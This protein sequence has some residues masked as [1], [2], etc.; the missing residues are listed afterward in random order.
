MSQPPHDHES[1]VNT[2]SPRAED[3]SNVPEPDDGVSTASDSQD[4]P[5]TESER[6]D[7][8]D[9]VEPVEARPAD[10]TSQADEPT[11]E[12]TEGDAEVAT[13]ATDPVSDAVESGADEAGDSAAEVID[14]ETADDIDIADTAEAEATSEDGSDADTEQ[15]VAPARR[16]R[17]RTSQRRRVRTGTADLKPRPRGDEEPS[18]RQVTVRRPVTP[19]P[20]TAEDDDH[21]ALLPWLTWHFSALFGL[22]VLALLGTMMYVAMRDTSDVLT[23][24]VLDADENPV[25][26]AIVQYGADRYRTD[27]NGEVRVEVLDDD[28]VL[29]IAH[30]GYVTRRATFTDEHARDQEVTLT[31]VEDAEAPES[32]NGSTPESGIAD[33]GEIAWADVA[34]DPEIAQ[35]GV[36]SGGVDSLSTDAASQGSNSGQTAASATPNEASG[37]EIA[38]KITNIDHEPV[39]SAWITDGTNFV[40]ADDDGNFVFPPGAIAP[41]TELTVSAPGYHRSKITAPEDGESIAFQME[42]QQIRGIYFNPNLSNNSEDIE[43]FID[44]ANRTEVNA[45][46]IDIKEELVFYDT[47]VQLFHDAG[48]V[49]PIL[50]LE[51][52]LKQFQDAGIYTIARLVVFKDSLIAETYPELGVLDNITGDLWR[53]MNGIAW[54]NPMDHTL[55]DAN[56]DLAVEA[57]NLGFDE[58]QYDYIRFPTDGELSR[59]EYGLENTQA[60]R[61]GAIEKFLQRSHEAL[62]KIGVPLSADIF[63]YTLIVEDDLGIGQNLDQ[64]IEH[65]DY[66]SPMIYPSHWPELSLGTPGHPNDY[67]YETVEVSMSVG[68]DQV[69]G[70]RLK[71]R[72]WLQDFNMPGMREYGDK[73]VRAQIDAVNDL[74]LSGWLMWDPNNWYHDGAYAK[75]DGSD[76]T[77]DA[78][79][80]TVST[81]V[82]RATPAAADRSE[83]R[84]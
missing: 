57:A 84:R 45:V 67:P 42:H 7:V 31:R 47:E 4:D 5:V 52:L 8:A 14:T 12:V 69:P 54:V 25:A 63:G 74:G 33:G 76:A 19:A 43:R 50:D 27:E 21:G 37:P 65:V 22:A 83:K 81:P 34:V 61:E 59:V 16:R 41:G 17:P 82:S 36:A 53:D 30:E 60:N 73:E 49:V 6:L 66:V 9:D 71:M 35:R 20:Q 46:V 68:L 24:E 51:A 77:E 58:I 64:L 80:V 48:A 13:D 55:W 44:I 56:I 11:V 40:F 62:V 29:M 3:E 10:D 72:P 1:E 39:E 18:R 2:T 38:G 79:P 32:E 15:V 75:P 26:D 78:T 23:L 28:S 70:Q